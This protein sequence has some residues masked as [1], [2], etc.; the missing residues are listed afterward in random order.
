MTRAFIDNHVMRV[1][2]KQLALQLR[3]DRNLSREWIAVR[4]KRDWWW[5]IQRRGRHCGERRADA[6]DADH[7]R[8]R[9]QLQPA[10]GLDVS[11]RI[12][13]VISETLGRTQLDFQWS[14]G[15]GRR[16]RKFADV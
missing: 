2:G 7:A 9:G 5:S 13:R 16:R 6:A 3:R 1:A 12:D 4:P 8:R 14:S 11:F 10:R 15:F